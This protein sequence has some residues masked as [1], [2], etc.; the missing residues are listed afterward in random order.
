LTGAASPSSVASGTSRSWRSSARCF[1]M[2][3]ARIAT[4]TCS[5][6]SL[7]D[8]TWTLFDI[9]HIQNE[10]S[11]LLGRKADLE[12]HGRRQPA[13]EDTS[14]ERQWSTARTT[15][16]GAISSSRFG[17]S[18]WRDDSLLLDMLIHARRAQKFAAKSSWDSFQSDDLTQ[19]AV[20]RALEVLGIRR[21]LGSA[22]SECAT[23]SSMNTSGSTFGGS[24]EPFRMI[25]LDSS[26]C[27]RSWFLLSLPPGLET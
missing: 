10:L 2:T 18:M 15:S 4:S 23:P 21:S 19:D 13:P 1:G 24:G 3:S 26:L 7:R 20:L 27:W 25:C 11:E 22:S 5:S 9:V 8:S 16:G 14:N 6:P 17:R 12:R